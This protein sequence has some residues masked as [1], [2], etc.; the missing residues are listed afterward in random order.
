MPSRFKNDCLTSVCDYALTRILGLD[1]I[2]VHFSMILLYMIV[3]VLMMISFIK[4]STASPEHNAD[5]VGQ[6]TTKGCYSGGWTLYSLKSF[7]ASH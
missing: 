5:P 2:Y 6:T 3:C 4:L 7:Q 1:F